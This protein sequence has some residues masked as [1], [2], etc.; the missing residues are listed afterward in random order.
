[1]DMDGDVVMVDKKESAK[2]CFSPIQ[3]RKLA[4]SS[5]PSAWACYGIYGIS[6]YRDSLTFRVLP[7]L[8]NF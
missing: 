3:N 6:E 4:S 7:F 8:S 5:V 2:Q 1:M